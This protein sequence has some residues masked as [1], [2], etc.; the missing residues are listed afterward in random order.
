MVSEAAVIL[1]MQH[2][3]TFLSKKGLVNKKVLTRSATLDLCKSLE[4]CVYI[5][6]VE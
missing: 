4:V 1:E 3:T 6:S 5:P 2:W